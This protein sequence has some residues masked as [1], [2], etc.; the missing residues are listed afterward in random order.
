MLTDRWIKTSLD[1]EIIAYK[2]SSFFNANFELANAVS[3]KSAAEAFMCTTAE[4]DIE[5]ADKMLLN[6]QYDKFIIKPNG[7]S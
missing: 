5:N 2:F 3:L 1:F 7:K 4:A 6:Y